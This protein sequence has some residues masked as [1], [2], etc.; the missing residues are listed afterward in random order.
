MRPLTGT[1]THRIVRIQ[2]RVTRISEFS[3]HEDLPLLTYSRSCLRPVMKAKDYYLITRLLLT[4]QTY[5]TL[6]GPTA[7]YKK[8]RKAGSPWT[9]AIEAS[10]PYVACVTNTCD[11]PPAII[12]YFRCR[13]HI[14]LTP[15]KNHMS[16]ESDPVQEDHSQ[17]SAVP[18]RNKAGPWAIKTRPASPQPC[19]PRVY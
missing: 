16:S 11:E 2:R 13:A 10:K 12:I 15:I 14:I 8:Q 1:R 19:N 9:S 7:V 17:D 5:L 3:Q 6:A 4:L 18:G